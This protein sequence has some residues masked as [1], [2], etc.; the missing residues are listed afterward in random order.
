VRRLTLSCLLA[1]MLVLTQLGAVSHELGHLHHEAGSDGAAVSAQLQ[2]G[3]SAFC[4]TCEAYAQ[5]SSPAVGSAD[6]LA[7]CPA[8]I[9]PIAAPCPP[10]IG[11]DAPTARSRGP[12][13]A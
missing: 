4:P 7:A 13:Q 6:A 5:V 1:L 3:Q 10:I 8:T 2:P 9:V 11:A 12:P